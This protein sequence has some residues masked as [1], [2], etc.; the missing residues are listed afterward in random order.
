MIKRFAKEKEED[1]ASLE[2]Y[3]NIR[4]DNKDSIKEIRS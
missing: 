2:E 4:K 3:D 1:N